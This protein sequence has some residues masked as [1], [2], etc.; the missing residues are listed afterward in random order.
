MRIYNKRLAADKVL[1]LVKT[2]LAKM[3]SDE[4]VTLGSYQ[5]GREQGHSLSM[6]IVCNKGLKSL[7]LGFAENRS[8]DDIVVY[9]DTT[10]D[11]GMGISDE[12]YKNAKYFRTEQE[13]CDYIV[14]EVENR[15]TALV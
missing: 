14:K 9:K 4:S 13:A 7:W 1:K 15:I 8:S 5:N 3:E 12:A 2:E 6:I 11:P 10:M